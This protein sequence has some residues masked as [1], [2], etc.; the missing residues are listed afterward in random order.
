MSNEQQN[1]NKVTS[2]RFSTS[3]SMLVGLQNGDSRQWDRFVNL[4]KE[5][6]CHWCKSLVPNLSG[7]NRE[8][9]VQNIFVKI[10]GAIDTFDLNREN[11]RFRAWLR[12]ITQTGIADFFREKYKIRKFVNRGSF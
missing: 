9:I 10:H 2:D 3:S 7:L 4:Y 1:S 11:R 6:V 5:L 8:E 12:T